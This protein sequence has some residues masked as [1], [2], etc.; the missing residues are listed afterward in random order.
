ALTAVA[1][2]LNS[3][4]NASE[5]SS[6]EAMNAT[7]AAVLP[8][9]EKNQI[10]G[11]AVG[12]V[13]GEKTYVFN[14]GVA[15]ILEGRPVTDATIFEIGSISK[16]FTATLATYAETIGKLQLSDTTAKYLPELAGSDFGD[17]QLIHLGTHT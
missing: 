8:A 7:F 17:L 14:Y 13:L 6:N 9:M 12:L 5:I 16:A 11:M 2:S 3:V 15:D 4:S 10:P 1:L